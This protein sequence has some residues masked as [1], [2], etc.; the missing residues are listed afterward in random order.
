MP[1]FYFEVEFGD[2]F[3][4]EQGVGLPDVRAARN[5]ALDTLAEMLRGAGE[6][7][8]QA[9][10]VFRLTAQDNQRRPVFRIDVTG[11]SI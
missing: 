5:V 2:V 8:W 6:E 7:F 4:D 11:R 9:G 1:R 3:P 10:G